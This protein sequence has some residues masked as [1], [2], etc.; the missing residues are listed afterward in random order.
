LRNFRTALIA[1]MGLVL[2]LAPV[3]RAQDSDSV[4]VVRLSLADGQ[5]L[6]SHPG[7]DAWEQAV[8]NLPLQEGD[9]LATQTGYAEVEFENGATA[10]LAENSTLQFTQLGFSD[11]G[12]VTDLSLTGGAGTFYANPTSQ[13][14]FRVRTFTFDVEIPGRAQ[15]R[16]DAF[17]DGAAVQV[18]LGRI[19]VTTP[20]GSTSLEKGQSAAVHGNDFQDLHIARLPEQDNFDQWV[21]QQSEIIQSG[22]QNTLR[23]INSPNEYGLSDLS[24]YGTWANFP[25]YGLSWRPYNVGFGWMPYVNGNWTFDPHLGWVW[26]SNEAW[27]WMPYH[28][29]SWMLSPTMGWVWLPGGR[30]GLRHWEPSRVN[31][32]R[33]GHH[34][35]WVAKNPNDRDGAPANLVD[36]VV[37]RPVPRGRDAN[38]SNEIVMGKELHGAAPLKQPPANFASRPAPVARR[39]EML[40]QLRNAPRTTDENASIVFDRRTRTFINRNGGG[41]NDSGRNGS[42][43]D[44]SE[45]ENGNDAGAAR[46]PRS[47]EQA[48]MPR[49]TI[50]STGSMDS[51]T[52]RV[53][54]PPPYLAPP[55]LRG[56]VRPNARRIPQRSEAPTAYVPMSRTGQLRVPRGVV[57]VRPPAP[58]RFTRP[59]A[60]VSE[61]VRTGYAARRAPGTKR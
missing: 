37:T 60:R 50:A 53:L 59:P 11:G 20:K 51:R 4:R 56:H 44:S 5:V 55:A 21:T 7:S 19:V 35:G 36:G 48:G 32:V 22:T 23:Y 58:Q 39:A 61:P 40:F 28:F 17:S 16:V 52:R 46:M 43:R 30:R 18:Q 47:G 9:T 6:V 45:P 13:D 57:N 10:Y 49:V 31:W 29:G 41:R 1:A 27:G 42:D 54:L 3:M 38:G 24:I 33:V 34:V 8:A 2:F 25:G 12:R 15:V 14:S 26:V